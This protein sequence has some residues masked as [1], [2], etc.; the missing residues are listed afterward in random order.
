[1]LDNVVIKAD[2]KKDALCIRSVSVRRDADLYDGWRKDVGIFFN[3]FVIY[4]T[5]Q[6]CS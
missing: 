3:I 5:V 1:M 4:V 6:P 2:E